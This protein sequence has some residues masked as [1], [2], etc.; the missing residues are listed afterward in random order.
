MVLV[1]GNR[2]ELD[3]VGQCGAHHDLAL[4]QDGSYAIVRHVVRT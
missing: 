1:L 3:D 4:E 2:M